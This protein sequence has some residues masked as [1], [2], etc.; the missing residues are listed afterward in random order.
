MQK[1]HVI[2]I[3]PKTGLDFGSTV[4][5]PHAVLA[6]AA[7]L[8]KAGYR[9]TI[10]DQRTQ[11]INESTLAPLIS[12]ELIFV[13]LSSMTGTQIR[14]A[15]KISG[16]VRNLTDG[17]VPIVWG[18]THPTIL[19]EQ[20]VS[21]PN[22]DIVVVGEGEL[23]TMEL[24]KA[25]ENKQPLFGI[26]G[27]CYKDGLAPV[28]NPTR[29]LMDVEELLPV[30]WHLIPVEKYIHR[31]MYVKN[32]T[33]TLD[34]GQ[35]SRGCPFRC[36]FCSSASIRGRKWRAMSAEKSLDMIVGSVR[37]FN[38]DGL[39]LRDDEFYINRD[40][41]HTIF[42]GMIRENLN[43][44]FYT[45][46]TRVDVFLQASDEELLA[47]KR[48]G[49]YTLKFGAESGSQRILDLMQKGITPEMTL[50]V[51]QKCKQLGIIPSFGLVIGYPTETFEDIDK[52]IDLAYRIKRENPDAQLE[53]MAQFTPLPGTPSWKLAEE[54]GLVSPSSL[55][56][57]CN[58]LFDDYDFAGEK[59]P[60]Y[61]SSERH[62]IGN[63]SY[64]SILAN[65]LPNVVDSMRNKTLRSV[66]AL[67]AKP[68]SSY[69]RF[70]LSNKL[71][72]G[73][74]EMAIV[75]YLRRKIFYESEATI[76]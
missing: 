8:D 3:Y 61:N 72:R 51:N 23:T 17:K 43:L 66:F 24:V 68:A 11:V 30:P 19:P 10:L 9:V 4:A 14:H 22:V 33:R 1:P 41:A 25:L 6:V 67:L 76:E 20:T 71:Y 47:M 36:G 55:E 62:W 13:G 59:L 5:P 57:W 15:L 56:G 26:A 2:L 58:W 70:R 53:T 21:H 52:T 16:M 29:P 73:A 50:K 12:D 28:L 18:G 74:P 45:S 46:G 42:E 7:P 37:K 54:H 31:D 60:W 65:A 69:F 27:L 40:R 35:T 34:I 63:I 39:W 64:M 38:L 48:A 75:R 49:A 32:S 44:S